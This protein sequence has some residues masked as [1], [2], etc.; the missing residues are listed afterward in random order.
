MKKNNFLLLA[1]VLTVIVFPQIT[2]AQMFPTTKLL[3][4][5]IGGYVNTIIRI[6]F[7]LAL[8]YFFWGTAQFVLHAGDSK[9]REDGKQ[10]MVWGVI[11]L[12]V[13]FSIYGIIAWIGVLFGVKSGG[14][15][16]LGQT[17]GGGT[18]S[19]TTSQVFNGVY[20]PTTNTCV[21]FNGN[22]ISCP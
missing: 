5:A 16:E 10:R 2:S 12:F 20:N 19:V 21:D 15:L 6:L 8:I 18:P 7:G 11:A 1:F 13:M 22:T 4:G 14:I 17:G 9:T 3:L